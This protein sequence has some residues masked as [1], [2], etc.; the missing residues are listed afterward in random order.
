MRISYFLIFIGVL[1]SACKGTELVKKEKKDDTTNIKYHTVLDNDLNHALTAIENSDELIKTQKAYFISEINKNNVYLAIENEID[2]VFIVDSKKS[3]VK[4]FLLIS[5]DGSDIAGM[6]NQGVLFGKDNISYENKLLAYEFIKCSK[7]VSIANKYNAADTQAQELIALIDTLKT[8][9]IN[10]S[11]GF[12]TTKR[13]HKK[14]KG[15]ANKTVVNKIMLEE[16]H[17]NI[18]EAKINSTRATMLSML[19]LIGNS[20]K[21]GI[22]LKLNSERALDRKLSWAEYKFRNIPLVAILPSI[23]KIQTDTKNSMKYLL[24]EL[25]R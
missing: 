8:Q 22:S 5:R 17:G 3:E 20:E 24:E 21:G 10:E 18:I 1:L 13:G 11:G 6:D 15:K 7:G 12:E 25:K 9:M 16:G 2:S 14:L 23:T 19:H 4:A